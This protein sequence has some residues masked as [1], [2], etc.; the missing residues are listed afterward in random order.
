MKK[1]FA[2][3]QRRRELQR[4]NNITNYVEAQQKYA[5]LP[6]DSHLSPLLAGDSDRWQDGHLPGAVPVRE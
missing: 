4:N 6:D 5:V 3:G 2:V 1:Y